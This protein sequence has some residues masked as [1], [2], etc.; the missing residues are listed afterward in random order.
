MAG[1]RVPVFAACLGALFS[2]A[3]AAPAD[4]QWQIQTNDGQATLRMG[5][6]AQPQLETLEAPENGATAVNLFIRRFRMVFGGNVSDKWTYFFET[7]SP[8]V[9]KA[10]PDRATNPGGAK[11]TGTV[12]IQDMFVTY[13][14]NLAFNVDVGLMLL[15]H[16]HNHLQSAASLLPVD[17]GPY[18]FLENGSLQERVARDYG[19]QVR[20]YPA[21]QHLEYRVDVLQGVRGPGATN[22][23][24]FSGRLV[25]YPFAAETEFFYAGTFQGSRRIVAFAASVDTQKDYRNY[26]SD[27]FV[28]LPIHNGEQGIT[29]QAQWIRYD[30][31]DFLPSLPKQDTYLF[32]A[33]Y[34]LKRGRCTPFVQYA[35]RD[36]SDV[37]LA[38]Q[39]ILHVGLAYWLSGHQRNL[40][41]SAGRLHTD[42]RSNQRQILAQLQIFFY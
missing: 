28:E 37:G 14:H 21:G 1:H 15:P 5:F 31:G 42:S 41:F 3:C 6:L 18:T 8:N 16:S 27:A 36:V 30:G 7:D 29:G 35:V 23:L 25:Y 10:N 40:K 12:F 32:E 4:A 38:D 2:I 26:G 24:R 9:G 22:P 33:G 17:Y 20:G 13:H 34:H 11:D 39:S 19:V